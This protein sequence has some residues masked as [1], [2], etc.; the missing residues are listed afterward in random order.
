MS[1]EMSIDVFRRPRCSL[2]VLYKKP[3]VASKFS[4]LCNPTVRRHIYPEERVCW[5]VW[6]Q[7]YQKSGIQKINVCFKLII[8]LFKIQIVLSLNIELIQV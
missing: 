2:L 1:A 7:M 4:I 3:L 6:F 8:F 5:W